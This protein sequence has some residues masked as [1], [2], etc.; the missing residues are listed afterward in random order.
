MLIAM[1]IIEV[2]FIKIIVQRRTLFLLFSL[3]LTA[4][5]TLAFFFAFC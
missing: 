1:N 5:Y 3:L 2:S 4:S